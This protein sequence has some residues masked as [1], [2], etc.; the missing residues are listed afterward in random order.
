MAVLFQPMLSQT[1]LFIFNKQQVFSELHLADENQPVGTTHLTPRSLVVTEIPSRSEGME[2]RHPSRKL[3][4]LMTLRFP[5]FPVTRVEPTICDLNLK[6]DVPG[7]DLFLSVPILILCFI[8]P[9]Y[10]LLKAL[11]ENFLSCGR[12]SEDCWKTSLPI[13]P[14]GR[15]WRPT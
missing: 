6:T 15:R 3:K 4:L 8:S 7:T 11:A 10:S 9:R 13:L 5:S 2:E 14:L 1:F 12:P